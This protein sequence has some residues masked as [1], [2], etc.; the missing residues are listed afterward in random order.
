VIAAAPTRKIGTWQRDFLV[1]REEIA[2]DRFQ[3]QSGRGEAGFPA[4]LNH[5][6]GGRPPAE[7]VSPTAASGLWQLP[8][9]TSSN[10]QLGK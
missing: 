5:A 3:R 1:A 9:R 6:T 8:Q 4:N 7:E 10:L 2:A